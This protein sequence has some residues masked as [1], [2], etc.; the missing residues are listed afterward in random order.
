MIKSWRK[1]KS[2]YCQA[3]ELRNAVDV[4]HIIARVDGGGNE[5]SNLIDLCKQCHRFAPNG[6][7]Q[8]EMFVMTK[9]SAVNILYAIRETLYDCGIKL[10]LAQEE[11]RILKIYN[12]IK[13]DVRSLA[14]FKTTI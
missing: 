7:R 3:C 9:G 13:R 6:H 5:E 4:H 10:T 1:V 8:I 12:K 14:D 11:K 2:K